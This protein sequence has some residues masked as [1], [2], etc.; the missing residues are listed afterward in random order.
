VSLVRVRFRQSGGFAGLLRGCEITAAESSP[1]ELQELERLLKESGVMERAAGGGARTP[2]T[3]ADLIQY[4]LEVETSDGTKH[5]VL[6]DD[7]L[8][9]RTEPLIQ[10]L[11]KRSKPVQP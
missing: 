2:P 7:D 8:N 11:Q 6:T 4:D 10:F 1:K 9:D 5:V 3:S